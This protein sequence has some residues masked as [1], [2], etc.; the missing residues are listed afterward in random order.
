MLNIES[1]KDGL[2]IDHI[3]AGSGAK[4]FS[5]LGLD[6]AEY[7]VWVK[8]FDLPQ[9]STLTLSIVEGLYSKTERKITSKIKIKIAKIKQASTNFFVI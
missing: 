2:V 9:V 5:W 4:I 3:R 1:I 7:S 6:K 8:S